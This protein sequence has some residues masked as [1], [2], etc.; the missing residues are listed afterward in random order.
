MEISGRSRDADA[1]ISSQ[2]F[3]DQQRTDKE[4]REEMYRA[5][6][7]IRYELERRDGSAH[8]LSYFLS[9]GTRRRKAARPTS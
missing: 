5:V 7:Q 1:G 8:Q 9:L 6:T 3:R 2:E 4:F